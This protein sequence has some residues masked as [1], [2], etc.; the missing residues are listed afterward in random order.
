MDHFEKT[1][2]RQKLV[3]IQCQGLLINVILSFVKFLLSSS[4]PLLFVRRIIM[5]FFSTDTLLTKSL[6]MIT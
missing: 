2:F 6:Q 5:N 3:K 1:W 4:A